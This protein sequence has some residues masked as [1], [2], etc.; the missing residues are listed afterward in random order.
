MQGSADI[1]IG[2]RGLMPQALI[3]ACA[4]ANIPLNYRLQN[5]YDHGYFFVGTFIG[6][7][8]KHHSKFLK[9]L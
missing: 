6:D 9:P 8:L 2:N 3:D 7:H 1:L 4:K 5:G